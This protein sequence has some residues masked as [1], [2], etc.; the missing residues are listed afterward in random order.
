MHVRRLL[1]ACLLVGTSV[2]VVATPTAA[3]A[4][5]HF[6]GGIRCTIVGTPGNDVLVGSK[7]R[8]VICGLGG[9][10][11]IRG[12]AGNDIIAGGPGEDAINGGRGSDRI[13]GGSGNDTLHGAAGSD[14]IEGD[15]GQDQ[16]DG[17]AGNDVQ[18]GGGGADVLRGGDGGDRITGA[19][20]DD[21]LGGGSGADD[22]DG[23]P[24]F[25]VCDE[26]GDPGDQQ[27]RCVVD[28]LPP[29]ATDLTVTP[30]TVDVSDS[31]QTIQLHAHV[32]DD[33]GVK[34]VQLGPSPASLVSG[35]VRDG[36]WTAS[37]RVPR[38]ID[39]GPQVITA[40]MTD[41]VGRWATADFSDAYAV[42]D[43]NPDT[44]AP[45]LQSFTQDKS[46]VDVRDTS[47]PI[48]AS[49][50]VTDDLAGPTGLYLCA[51]RVDPAADPVPPSAHQVRPDS[52]AG[53]TGAGCQVMHQTSGNPRDSTWEA[54]SV[55][56]QGAVEGT[57]NFQVW[58]S[59]ASGNRN[60]DFWY[61]PDE[62]AALATND[63]HDHA[64]P[65]G[66]G[67]FTVQ[68][69]AP[70]ANP[71]ALTSV[72]LS[73]STVDTSSGAVQVT[74]DISGTDVE[75]I[76]HAMLFVT[77]YPG[78]PDHPD[79]ADSVVLAWVQSFQLVS[80]TP[81]DGTWRATFVVPGG[82]P[83][84]SYFLQATL[85]DSGHAEN[86]V[87]PGSGWET[88]NHLLTPDLAPSGQLFVVANS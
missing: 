39:P 85:T 9:N 28:T 27:V 15:S 72:T 87:S 63:P 16:V 48:T 55:V 45:V 29:A 4:A 26:P 60:T 78:Y 65:G 25:N 3:H 75:G 35:T 52:E 41:R 74:A 64:I 10:D 46:S 8:D 51:Y 5:G 61:G 14:I 69:S 13:S 80:G 79:Y 31:A 40:Y 82:E 54:T 7:H 84:G 22:V 62:L 76:T 66:G 6:T 19:R 18:N 33:T 20:G 71:P 34:S 36:I 32:T 12:R 83:D 30:A 88:G 59:D 70:D 77:G 56:P 11:R 2:A 43:S 50:R 44:Q 86:W 17:D 81:Q 57:W 37:I 38:Y 67:A 24:G 47:Q 1:S 68:G 23:G 53:D 21:D 42:L 49:I 58:I 73:P